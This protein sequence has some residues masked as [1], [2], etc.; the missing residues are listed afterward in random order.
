LQWDKYESRYTDKEWSEEE[1]MAF[2]DALSLHGPEL[3]AVRD[4]VHT[5]DMG[6]IVRRFG[7][8]KKYVIAFDSLTHLANTEDK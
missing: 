7:L 2:E 5:R 4:E 3:R 8:F 6:E 1:L